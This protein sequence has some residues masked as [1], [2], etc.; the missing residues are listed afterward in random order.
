MSPAVVTP[1][2][3][4]KRREPGKERYRDAPLPN[5]IRERK[6]CLERLAQAP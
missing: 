5:L 2:V 4:R 3:L 1:D 6:Q